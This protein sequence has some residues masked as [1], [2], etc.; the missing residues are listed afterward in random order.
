MVIDNF[1]KMKEVFDNKTFT[2][3]SMI[4]L[5]IIKRRKENPEHKSNNSVIRQMYYSTY[6]EVIERKDDIVFECTAFN[7]RCYIWPVL[8]SKKTVALRTLA[9][10]A[11]MIASGQYNV[12]NVYDSVAGNYPSDSDK[13]WVIDVDEIIPDD[14]NPANHARQMYRNDMYLYLESAVQQTG[15]TPR[16]VE[17]PTK[18]GFHWLTQPFN[19]AEFKKRYPE[20]DVHKN[21]P[22]VLYIP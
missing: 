4:Y 2:E 1:E 3:D 19:L 20:V 13:L 16:F 8:R 21:N 6:D 22:T 12:R 18:N 14:D 9:K 11:D 5:Q 15:K 17:I 10:A 7:A